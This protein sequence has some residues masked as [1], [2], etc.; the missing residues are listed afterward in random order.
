MTIIVL[1]D[2]GSI[3]APGAIVKNLPLTNFEV[4]NNFSNTSISIGL[5]VNLNTTNKD[6]L[7]SSVNEVH[8]RLINTTSNINSNVATTNS[9]VTNVDTRVNSVESN[10]GLIS[11]LQTTQNANIVASINQ[12][13][14]LAGGDGTLEGDWAGNVI[15]VQYG[16]TGANTAT[17]AR[18]NLGLQIGANVQAWDADLDTISGLSKTA[19]NFIVADGSSWTSQTLSQARQSLELGTLALQNSNN[20]T[21]TGGTLIGV[22]NVAVSGNVF[23]TKFFG[24]GS[25]LTG[26]TGGGGSGLFNTA[27]SNST[28]VEPTTSL[29]NAYIAPSTAGTRYV[30]HSIH[31][32]NINGAVTAN[33]SGD[34]NGTDYS[35]ISI[36]NII[37]VPAGSAVELLKK[38]KV[39]QPTDYIRLTSDLANALH[40]TIIVETS[41]ETGLF[42]KGIDIT[43]AATYT[44]LHTATGNT[45]IESVFLSNDDGV[46]DVKA[47]V[48]WTDGSNNI[49]GYYC[50]D[51]IIP[52]DATVELLEQPKFL[53]SGYKV[54][55]YANTGNRL[56]AMIAGKTA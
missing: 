28:A 56:E 1:R 38:P 2:S 51:L 37:P 5:P 26:I 19:N 4:D 21:I 20:V 14:N 46:N 45:V 3:T 43:S 11:N 32:T 54:R 48:V 36:S 30:V 13:W 29:A 12:L 10:V 55:V 23:A 6:N 17:Q 31:V 40:T 22:S 27:I 25:A 18:I 7:V 52:A 24:D 53:P 8:T 34:F 47:R 9:N 49:Q 35:A 44:D 39:L 15:L 42:G 33:I 50:Y 16:G 41:T